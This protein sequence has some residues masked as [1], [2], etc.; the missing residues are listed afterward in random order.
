MAKHGA[1]EDRLMKTHSC[2]LLLSCIY[3][4]F[5]RGHKKVG[6]KH[7]LLFQGLDLNLDLIHSLFLGWHVTSSR[8]DNTA[9]QT[10][11]EEPTP[12]AC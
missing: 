10:P 7:R 5:H 12:L 2:C 6:M 9:A 11:T 1:S 3:R 8:T 4:L